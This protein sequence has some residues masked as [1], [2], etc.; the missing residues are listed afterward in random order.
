MQCAGIL[1]AAQGLAAQAGP[2]SLG[3]QPLLKSVQFL[4]HAA[5]AAH[6]RNE[7]APVRTSSRMLA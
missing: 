3:Y 1:E 5:G 7:G 2:H 4:Q 6:A